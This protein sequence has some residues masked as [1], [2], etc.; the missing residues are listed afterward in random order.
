[1]LNYVLKKIFIFP[2]LYKISLHHM[3]SNIVP[4]LIMYVYNSM[5]ICLNWSFFLKNQY[6]IIVP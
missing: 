4:W 2:Q 3:G 1:M 5:N 6:D